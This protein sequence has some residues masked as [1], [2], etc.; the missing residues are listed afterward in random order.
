MY[1][2]FG[3]AAVLRQYVAYNGV[4]STINAAHDAFSDTRLSWHPDVMITLQ[5][6]SKHEEHRILSIRSLPSASFW[7]RALP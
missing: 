4:T 3:I 7:Y 5:R 2:H 1:P 6:P